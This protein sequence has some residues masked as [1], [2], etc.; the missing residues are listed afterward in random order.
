MGKYSHLKG[1]LTQFVND[2]ASWTERVDARRKKILEDQPTSDVLCGLLMDAKA[3][4]SRLEE[5]KT[6]LSC[7]VEALEKILV[8]RLEDQ[9]LTQIKTSRG[10]FSIKDE[11][12]VQFVDKGELNKWIRATGQEDLLSVNPKTAE[13]IVKNMVLEGKEPPPGSKIYMDVGI[14]TLKAKES[15]E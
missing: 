15:A 11:P 8:E 9:G 7:D 13:G 12:I 5:Q 4:K 2:D 6:S 1:K 10:T 3:E 14:G